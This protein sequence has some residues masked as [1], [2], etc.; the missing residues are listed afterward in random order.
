LCRLWFLNWHRLAIH[1]G[2]DDAKALYG[3]AN[4]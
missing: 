2:N 3:L 4:T 1:I